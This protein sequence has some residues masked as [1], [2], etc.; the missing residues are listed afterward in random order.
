MAADAEPFKLERT[1]PDVP[2]S[3][4]ARGYYLGRVG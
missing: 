4:E 3:A 2:M 1:Q